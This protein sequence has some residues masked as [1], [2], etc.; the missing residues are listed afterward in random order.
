M[1]PTYSIAILALVMATSAHART[2]TEQNA[3]V[4]ERFGMEPAQFESELERRF[5][6][7]P[8]S[9]PAVVADPAE[10]RR[11]DAL[12]LQNFPD[13][14][15]AYSMPGRAQAKRLAADLVRD[16]RQLSHEQFVLR[17]AEIAALAGNAHSTIG[18]NALRKG[19]A[20]VPIRTF[21]FADGLHVVR[22]APTHA[23]LLGA[24]ID[25]IGDR[26]VGEIYRILARYLP[27]PERRRRLQLLPVLESPALL[28]A[29]GLATP[30]DRLRL[31][32]RLANGRRFDRV[33]TA[34]K[35]DRA[36][37]ISNTAR[38]LFPS[39]ATEPMQSLLRPL[40]DDPI[41]LRQSSK[42]FRSGELPGRGYYVALT[43]NGNADE[44]P[45]APFL[46]SA[47]AAVRTTRPNYMV[48]DMRMNGGGDYTTTYD[49]ARAQPA[50]TKGAPIYVLTSP[51][52][53]SAAITTVAALK[54]AGG[55]QVTIVGE[56][57]GDHLDFWAEGGTLSLPNSGID[58]HYVGARHI[59]SGPCADRE[60]CF[61]LNELYP[62]RV[63]SLDPDIAVPL[64]F[65]AYARRIDPA[66]DAIVQREQRAR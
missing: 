27:G 37:P 2:L 41:W 64:T 19:T 57:V 33:I 5:Q 3:L 59:Y 52:T 15:R 46:Q 56:Q 30:A 21:L 18:E 34:E 40:S 32:G 55:K 42:M 39:A 61:W 29:A 53:F 1:R 38:L 24:R 36:A 43:H 28:E 7:A 12:Y 48:I 51:W 22:A 13:L 20:R 8:P 4:R 17:A 45:I 9:P 44:E 65:A 62:V 47:L 63:R 11:I 14:D 23:D 35:R 31:R 66:I 49:F 60:T 25:M 54:D 10:G 50:A 58:L 26:S 6:Y 16:A